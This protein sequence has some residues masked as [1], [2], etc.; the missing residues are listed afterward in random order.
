MKI[1]K[2]EVE[3]VAGLARLDLQPEEV[4]RIT[5]QL[6]TLLRYVTK[7]D[8]VDTEGV[9]VTTHTQDVCNA[10]RDDEVRDSLNR[11]QALANGP[12]QNGE[13]FVVPRIL[14]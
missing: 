11:E 2:E 3:H 1:T 9:P 14:S 4:E 8:E 12:L 6:D 5:D 10:F 7:L 13:S